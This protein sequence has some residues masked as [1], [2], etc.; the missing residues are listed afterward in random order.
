MEKNW[1]LSGL[2]DLLL[3][4]FWTPYQGWCI[5]AG[6]DYRI[7]DRGEKQK[8]L[9]I[10]SDDITDYLF[11]CDEVDRLRDFW[12]NADKGDTVQRPSFI[13]DWALSKRFKPDWLEW[14]IQKK[15]Y[16]TTE[17][18]IS[19][20]A[21]FPPYETDLLKLLNLAIS[22]FFNPRKIIDAKKEEVTQW[23]KDKGAELNI[24]VSDNMADSIFTIIKPKNHNP[25][26]KRAQS[27][28]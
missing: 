25:K 7:L 20:S 18:K 4:D 19:A 13:I 1:E 22:E 6:L 2:E 26:I 16:E 24:V 10:N 14:A 9:F 21:I 28:D 3:Y 8:A 23:L 15:L 17:S 11:S 12:L 27:V 5:L